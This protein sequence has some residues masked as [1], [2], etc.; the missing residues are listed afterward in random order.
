[1]VLHLIFAKENSWFNM[2]KE[3]NFP[4][5]YM[6]LKLLIAGIITLY[7]FFKYL[8]KFS[9]FYM[10]SIF[11]YAIFDEILQLHE[12]A[13]E[14]YHHLVENIFYS[15]SR[16]SW[17]YLFAPI[18]IISLIIGIKFTTYL[19]KYKK[20]FIYGIILLSLAVG[21]EIFESIYF[22]SP[23]INT[24]IFIEESLE[25]ISIS[26]FIFSIMG[27]ILSNKKIAPNTDN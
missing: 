25:K 20:Y 15:Q 3:N 23:Y 4:T 22:D 2:G 12:Q 18:L 1:M 6:G 8:R 21:C 10:G 26:F 27:A 14:K 24:S 19:G 9:V 13:S 11:I 5:Y 17:L 7:L 16:F